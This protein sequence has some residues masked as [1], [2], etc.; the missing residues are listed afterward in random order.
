MSEAKVPSPAD[1]MYPTLIA[2]EQLGGSATNR[3]LEEKVPQ[4][5]GLSDRQ[6]ALVFQK[7]NRKGENKVFYTMGWARTFLKKAGTIDNKN[8]GV[9]S[10][11][12]DGYRFLRMDPLEA[13]RGLRQL[14]RDIMETQRGQQE[15][16][17]SGN[18]RKIYWDWRSKLLTIL[19]EM[20][21]SDFEKMIFKLLRE[22]GF[23]DLERTGRMKDGEVEGVGK[24]SVPNLSIYIQCKRYIAVV[25]PGALRKFRNAMDGRGDRGLFITT[26]TF[27]AEAQAEAH[28]MPEIDLVDGEK[29]CDLLK[30]QRLGVVV[31]KRVVEDITVNEGF[32][33]DL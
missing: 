16:N 2:I 23:G 17:K 13:D 3:Q 32:F 15:G 29:L 9:W 24:M 22:L 28:M 18:E 10:I 5:A 19:K 20:R 7:G 1:L 8:R 27:S 12:Q 6:M 4:I 30:E 31:E 25:G 21:P 14:Q 11:A 33:A 26:S